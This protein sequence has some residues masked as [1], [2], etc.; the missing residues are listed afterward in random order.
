MTAKQAYLEKAEARL[1]EWQAE[2]ETLNA[3]AKMAKAEAKIEYQR[4][5]DALSTKQR[6]AQQQL[7]ELKEAGGETWETVKLKLER[8]LSTLQQ[9]FDQARAALQKVGD[10]SLG[11]AEGMAEKLGQGSQGWPE[12]LGRKGKGS[13]GWAE[14]LG[15]QAED[16]AGWP[17][18]MQRR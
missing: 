1:K 4:R 11:W 18:G 12:G 10:T 16:S 3:Q 15:H 2:I 14:G 5:L 8:A 7:Q 13:E 6:L 9:E 17:E